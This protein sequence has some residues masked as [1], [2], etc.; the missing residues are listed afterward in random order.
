MVKSSLKPEEK[1]TESE[2]DEDENKLNEKWIE[3]LGFEK[4]PVEDQRTNEEQTKTDEEQRKIFTELLTETSRKRYG[5][6]SAWIL[7]TE[8]RFFHSK[9]LK[10]TT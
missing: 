7:F 2:Q 1:K 6:T 9:H 3:N 8:S 4:L 10:Y 5:S